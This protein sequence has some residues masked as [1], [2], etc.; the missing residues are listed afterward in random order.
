MTILILTLI[1]LM[2]RSWADSAYY[3]RRRTLKHTNTCSY[4][5]KDIAMLAM[6][7]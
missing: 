2:A 4:Y 1:A 6:S 7:V 3:E 5:G